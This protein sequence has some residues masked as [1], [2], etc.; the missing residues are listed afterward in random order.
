[1]KLFEVQSTV[2]FVQTQSYDTNSQRRGSQQV[3]N[4]SLCESYRSIVTNSS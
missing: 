4:S 3:R 2:L 1:L